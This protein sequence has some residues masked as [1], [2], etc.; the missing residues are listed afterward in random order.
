MI[1]SFYFDS[2][3]FGPSPVKKAEKTYIYSAGANKVVPAQFYSIS[4]NKVILRDSIVKDSLSDTGEIEY[5]DIQP[6][7]VKIN[8]RL[9][10]STN[11]IIEFVFVLDDQVKTTTRKVYTF[12]DALSNT[13]GFYNVLSGLLALVVS[14]SGI[15][16][17]FFSGD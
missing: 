10:A 6:T 4:R 1:Q 15:Q 7:Y 11:A 3:D 2:T 14:G 9:N 5:T 8:E 13:G 12:F 17:Q 16:E